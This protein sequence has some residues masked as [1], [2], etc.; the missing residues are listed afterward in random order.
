MSR[1]DQIFIL[2]HTKYYSFKTVNKNAI[3]PRHVIFLYGL[4]WLSLIP[5]MPT[6]WSYLLG[7]HKGVHLE[8]LQRLKEISGLAVPDFELC[9]WLVQPASCTGLG[10]F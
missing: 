8:K 7:K 9:Y 10:L 5:F 6:F 4:S 2:F 3:V 1:V